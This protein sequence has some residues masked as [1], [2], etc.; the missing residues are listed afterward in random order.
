MDSFSAPG[1]RTHEEIIMY[2]T[3]NNPEPCLILSMEESGEF[4]RAAS[5]V[6]RHGLTDKYKAQL[7]EEAGDV[8][9]CLYLLES[10]DMFTVDEVLER[11]QKKLDKLQSYEENS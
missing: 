11:A 2:F 1:K 9:A 4:I 8:V 7:I 6:I 10:H 5:K 3:I